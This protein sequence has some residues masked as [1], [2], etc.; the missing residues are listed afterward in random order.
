MLAG[1]SRI[2]DSNKYPVLSIITVV[3]NG[4]KFLERTIN[5]VINQTFSNYEFIIIDGRSTDST[6]S[7]IKK[8]ENRIDY[9]ISEKDNGIY[10]AMNKGL[11]I[12]KGK[13]INFMNCSDIYYSNNTLNSL[14]S[15]FMLSGN[16]QLIYSDWYICNA[17]H[18]PNVLKSKTSSWEKGNILH[19][20]IIYDK[21]LH[22]KYGLY[23]VS[24]NK[25]ISDYLFFSLIPIALVVKTN[26]PISINDTSGISYG[27]WCM[28]Q[29]AI[30]D[31]LFKR[32]NIC[33][34][35]VKSIII[36]LKKIIKSILKLQ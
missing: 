16:I 2:S 13:W 25:L 24:D 19:Q 36:L 33:S 20:S 6:L 22:A 35:L 34:F 14:F 5:S 29:K 18:S 4:E 10:D 8:Y 17:L 26:I 31:L 15:P 27:N 21:K 30:V 28:E 1:G 7:I 32:I 11:K 23:V 12:A 9:W 3:Y